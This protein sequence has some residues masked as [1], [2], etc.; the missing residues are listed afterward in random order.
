MNILIVEDETNV[1]SFIHRGLSEEGY[2][3]SLAMDGQ[4][5]LDMI[6][7]HQYDV[8]I[9][10][11]MLPG[12]NGMD[13]CRKI[14]AMGIEVPVIMLT[15]LGATENIV[16][17]LQT[18]ADDYLV[19][20]FKFAELLARIEAVVRR[21]TKNPN[22]GKLLLI[23][24]LEIDTLAKIVKREGIIINLTAT[25][26][27]L[28]EYLTINRGIVLSREQI[29]GNVWDINFDMN[30]NVVDVYINYLR[31][32]IDKNFSTKLIHTIVG[33]GYTL[34]KNQ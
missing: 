32:K 29:L 34:R 6:L 19:K 28:L 5:A 18:G 25:E 15:A 24:S 16:S 20:P 1:A 22:S 27:K 30:T 7:N 26:Y 10:D 14:R 31:K 33:M 11:I 12:M 21:S 23:D 8:L 4:T 2:N 9:L 17:G 3:P 13:L